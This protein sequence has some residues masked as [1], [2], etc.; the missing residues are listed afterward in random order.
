MFWHAEQRMHLA[1]KHK[2]EA[3]SCI[4]LHVHEASRFADETAAPAR[5]LFGVY[6]WCQGM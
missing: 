4:G 5:L 2:V 3:L 1:C 6:H